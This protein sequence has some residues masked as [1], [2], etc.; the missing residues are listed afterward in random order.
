M[1]NQKQAKI[2][3]I[4]IYP[5]C[6]FCCDNTILPYSKKLV[7]DLSVILIILNANQKQTDADRTEVYQ[8]NKV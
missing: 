3:Q 8:V 7:K 2:N 6:L 5:S 4:K 1:I